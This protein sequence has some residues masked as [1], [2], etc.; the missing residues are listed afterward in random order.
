MLRFASSTWLARFSGVTEDVVRKWQRR[1]VAVK[2]VSKKAI[3]PAHAIVETATVLRLVMASGVRPVALNVIRRLK[4]E[5]LVAQKPEDTPDGAQRKL[6]L[7]TTWLR[8]L[9]K[10]AVMTFRKGTTDMQSASFTAAE[11]E[12]VR[13]V[14][15]SEAGSTCTISLT[16]PLDN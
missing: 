9:M 13:L 11:I 4:L 7:S 12:K 15:Q 3:L 14:P 16:E 6:Q 2:S 8:F 10:N 5:H 1:G